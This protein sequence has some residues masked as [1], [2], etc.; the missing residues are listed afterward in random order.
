MFCETTEQSDRRTFAFA[1]IFLQ[2]QALSK[3]LR[4]A[5]PIVVSY[6]NQPNR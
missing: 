2:E 1:E 4:K 6:T 5:E 3:K